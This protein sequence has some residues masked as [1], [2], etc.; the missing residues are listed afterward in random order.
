M[1]T[2]LDSNCNWRHR[3]PDEASQA[4][5]SALTPPVVAVTANLTEIDM[6]P[7]KSY[8]H[9]S[10]CMFGFLP[11]FIPLDDLTVSQDEAG[12]GVV[13]VIHHHLLLSSPTGAA[14][15]GDA[16]KPDK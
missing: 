14:A 12:L 6:F 15:A 13:R 3:A 16:V 10:L 11:L 5:G 1:R 8:S 9:I 2:S 7:K 4:A